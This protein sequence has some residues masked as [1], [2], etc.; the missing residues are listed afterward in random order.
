[1][2]LQSVLFTEPEPRIV[3][4]DKKTS[5]LYVKQFHYLK[6]SGSVASVIYG[7]I[8]NNAIVGISEWK[9]P[10]GPNL[11]VGAFG[12]DKNT[13][14]AGFFEL[15][16]FVLSENIHNRA[17]MFL[18][19]S[20]KLLKQTHN[21]RALFTFADSRFHVG[22]IYQAT[23]WKYYGLTAQKTDF[24]IN[25]KK[26]PWGKVGKGVKW[27]PRPRKHRYAIVYDK[28]LKMKWLEHPY[29][30]A[31]SLDARDINHKL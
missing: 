14:Q 21:P 6:E 16:R 10:C 27:K 29:P 22:T 28:T 19:A 7:L 25:G 15:G 31:A 30:K 17:S 1:M 4:I 9:P 26:N 3:E 8:I 5:S 2:T 24:F 12:L 13:G 20:I 23:N 18:G 11:I